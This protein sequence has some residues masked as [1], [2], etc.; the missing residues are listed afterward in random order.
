[1]EPADVFVAI[2]ALAIFIFYIYA[3]IA[4]LSF[5]KRTDQFEKE[6]RQ[7]IVFQ[8]QKQYAEIQQ[9]QQEQLRQQQ[10]LLKQQQE[11]NG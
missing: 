9:K 3:I 1:M 10:E 2:V 4:A 8:N 6:V 11:K 7:W 5:I